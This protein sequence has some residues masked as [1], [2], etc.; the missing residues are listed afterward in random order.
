MTGRLLKVKLADCPAP[1]GQSDHDGF[2]SLTGEHIRYSY[3]GRDKG[4]NREI[5]IPG[6]RKDEDTNVMTEEQAAQSDEFA[7]PTAV[8]SALSALQPVI[9]RLLSTIRGASAFSEVVLLFEDPADVNNVL[10]VVEAASGGE[11]PEPVTDASLPAW[12]ELRSMMPDSGPAEVEL[13]DSLQGILTSINRPAPTGALWLPLRFEGRYLG[14]ILLTGSSI[15]SELSA[16]AQIEVGSAAD[17]LASLLSQVVRLERENEKLIQLI[18]MLQVTRTLMRESEAGHLLNMVLN[19]LSRIVGNGRMALLPTT[20]LGKPKSFIRQ[21]DHGEVLAAH[22][23]ILSRRD[24]RIDDQIQGRQ[25]GLEVTETFPEEQFSSFNRITPWILRDAGRSYLGTLYLYDNDPAQEDTLDHSVIRTIIVELERTLRR[26]LIEDDAAHAISELPYRI[27]SREYWLRRFE[28]EINLTG[29][30]G[31][32]VTCGVVE[33][34]DYERLQDELDDLVLNESVLT[35]VQMVKASIRDTDLICRLDRN[36]FGLL[37]LDAA[38]KNVLPALERVATQIRSMAGTSQTSTGLTFV[39]GLSEFPWDGEAVP[40][41]LRKAWTATAMARDEGSF[42]L[43]LYNE[44]NARE[45]L[46]ENTGIREEITVHLEL[47]G[48]LELASFTET[49]PPIQS[50]GR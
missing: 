48:S 3:I 15:G 1:T 16:A 49:I 47:L 35:L 41:L 46:R 36:H 2:L 44:D 24:P 31:T 6:A 23:L 34:L 11:P 37:F 21:V 28:E 43:N 25:G 40:S 38:K 13:G 30:R 8:P 14:G 7:A 17:H 19:T 26:Y 10:M 32:R 29:R 50:E 9:L 22:E 27:W 5:H 45:F 39:S 4:A 33:L 20:V 42:N 12:G 18:Q